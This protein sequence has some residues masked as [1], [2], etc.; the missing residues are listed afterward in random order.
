LLELV[1]ILAQIIASAI[2]L[3]FYLIC[4]FAHCTF[5]FTV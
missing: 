5:S 4:S 3:P 2:D 1:E